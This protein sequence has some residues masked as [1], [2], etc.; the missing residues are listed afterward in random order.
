MRA[1]VWYVCAVRAQCIARILGAPDLASIS[2]MKVKESHRALQAALV[3]ILKSQIYCHFLRV[4]PL[5]EYLWI[6]E[7]ASD[8]SEMYPSCVISSDY[9]AAVRGH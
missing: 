1:C 7:I 8:Y 4:Y 5:K 2:G 6:S 3:K 9:F